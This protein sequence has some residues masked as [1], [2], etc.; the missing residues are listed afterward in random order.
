M[1]CY[2]VYDHNNLHG[3]SACTGYK[4]EKFVNMLKMFQLM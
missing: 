4:T 1:A 3:N 2:D